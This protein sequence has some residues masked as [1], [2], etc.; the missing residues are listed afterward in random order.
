MTTLARTLGTFLL[1]LPQEAPDDRL[2]GLLKEA[3][4]SDIRAAYRAVERLADLGPAALA[5]IEAAAKAAPEGPSG[6]LALAADEIRARR[7]LKAAYPQVRRFSATSTSRTTPD[8][9]GDL[10]TTTGLD[11]EFGDLLEEENLPKVAVDFKDASPF[12]ALAEI[13]RAG[14]A[15]WY[16]EDGVVNVYSGGFEDLPRFFFGHFMITL[17]SHALVRTVR[18]GEPAQERLLLSLHA[19]WNPVLL[20]AGGRA[21]RLLEARD[22]KGRSLVPPPP[23]E[24]AAEGEDEAPTRD[25]GGIYEEL[26]LLPLARGSQKI[27]VLR[28]EVPLRVPRAAVT[29]EFQKPKAGAKQETEGVTVTVASVESKGGGSYTARLELS[30]A[31]MKPEDLVKK[32]VVLGLKTAGGRRLHADPDLDEAEGKIEVSCDFED[33]ARVRRQGGAKPV[34]PPIESLTLFYIRES[35]ERRVPF[36]FRDLKIK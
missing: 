31:G 21:P 32:W 9:L 16:F 20:A 19:G 3:E 5:A 6:R 28:G 25:A 23:K 12:E 35:F 22:E 27:A 34:P 2:A 15:S 13:C 33:P 7:D 14:S 1:F 11:L 24:K 8:L 36:E 18:F 4:A 30:V 17:E 10:R 29:V 26:E